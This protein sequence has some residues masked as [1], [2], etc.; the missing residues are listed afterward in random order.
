VPSDG[1]AECLFGQTGS[2]ADFYRYDQSNPSNGAV[3]SFSP[4]LW[5]NEERPNIEASLLPPPAITSLSP[6]AGPIKNAIV[7][8]LGAN[9]AAVQG[10][11]F[12]GVPARSFT[13]DS[14]GQ[15]SA[16]AP[17]SASLGQ[18]P[19]AVKTVAGTATSAQAFA[20]EGCEVPKLKGKK[21]KESKKKARRSDCRIGKVRKRGKVTAKTGR[22]VKQNP[23]PGKILLPGAKI[24]VTLGG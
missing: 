22:V 8:I 10:V 12:G 4:G 20:Y 13:V 1:N 2:E 18:V 21:L 5:G 23:K 7:T 16:L 19:I 17:D 14:E 24:K 15:I 6:T 9:F 3:F 11:S